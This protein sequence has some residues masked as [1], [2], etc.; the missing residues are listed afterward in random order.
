MHSV[1]PQLLQQNCSVLETPNQRI[2]Q[3]HSFLGT[4]PR[5][6]TFITPESIFQFYTISKI[7]RFQNQQ[8]FT[9]AQL[10]TT[11]NGHSHVQPLNL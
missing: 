7:E 6:I 10:G 8:L 3:Y 11:V 4:M 5:I 9:V 2:H 1:Q